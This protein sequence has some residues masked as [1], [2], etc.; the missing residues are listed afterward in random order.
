M[1]AI[2]RVILLLLFSKSAFGQANSLTLDLAAFYFQ[3]KEERANNNGDTTKYE[4]SYLFYSLGLCYRFTT[5]CLGGKYYSGEIGSL[6]S[7]GIVDGQ[8]EYEGFGVTFGAFPD[9]WSLQLT[10]FLSAEKR[11]GDAGFAGDTN[12]E[13]PAKQ[14]YL[15]D[16]AYGF[17]AG[18]FSVGPM[19]RISEFSYDKRTVA[20]V[21]SSL[22]NTE[23]D[24]MQMPMV[25]FWMGF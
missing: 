6:N 14:A 22:A 24:S 23:K 9:N 2:V 4:Q 13:Y 20:G 8:L 1:K 18:S 7:S 16:I 10:Y 21:E 25:A 15:I 3:T 17:K 19:L 11:I 12:I 5:F